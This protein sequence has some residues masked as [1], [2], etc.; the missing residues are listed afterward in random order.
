MLGRGQGRVCG[1]VAFD[2]RQYIE[3]DA[4]SNPGN[5]I[6][7]MNGSFEHQVN[8]DKKV[9]SKKTNYTFPSGMC[10]CGIAVAENIHDGN[11]TTSSSMLASRRREL[12]EE[13]ERKT[14]RD[15]GRDRQTERQ[16]DTDRESV[17][18][19]DRDR[20]TDRQTERIRSGFYT[21][22]PGRLR[23]LS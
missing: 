9:I 7:Q 21:I 10:N 8:V 6:A 1:K 19:T 17:R 20:Q 12:E 15:T 3:K 13:S 22:F 5:L 4:C 16:R 14:D 18:Q 2:T 11:E 23:E